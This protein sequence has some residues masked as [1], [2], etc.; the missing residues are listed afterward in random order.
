MS[1]ERR[2]LIL[3]FTLGLL[4][5]PTYLLAGP[6]KFLTWYA[7]VLGGGVFSTAHWLKDLRPSRVAWLTWLAWPPVLLLGAAASLALATLAA[8][9]CTF[10]PRPN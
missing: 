7:L 6:D 8:A 9:A 10:F 2:E 4:A 3:A 1:P 5:G